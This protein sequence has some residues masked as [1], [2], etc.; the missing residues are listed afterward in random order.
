MSSFCEEKYIYAIQ[1][2]LRVDKKKYS[3]LLSDYQLVTEG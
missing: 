3:E 1:S 2:N